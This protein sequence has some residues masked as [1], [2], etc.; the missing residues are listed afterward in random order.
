MS[1]TDNIVFKGLHILAWV[2]FIGLCI[3]AGGMLFN[4][5]LSIFKPEFVSN[6]YQK[7]DLSEIYERSEWAYYSMYSLVLMI[8]FL[9]ANLFYVVVV[10]L[11]KLDLANPF[12]NF[13]SSKIAEISYFTFSIGIVSFIAR[14]SAKNLMH[15]GYSTEVL[16]QF[17]GDSQAFILMAA[18]IYIISVIFRKGIAIQAENDLTV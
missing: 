7:L 1:T 18:I 16:N 10:L 2:I 11:W 9:K 14:Q 17:W 3:E 12:N 15:R 13:V 4:F 5:I 8:A 6:L